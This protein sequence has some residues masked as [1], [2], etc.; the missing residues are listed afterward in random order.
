[1][2]TPSPD[3]TKNIKTE[4]LEE[5]TGDQILD[6]REKGR[7]QGR[8][9]SLEIIMAWLKEFGNVFKMIRFHRTELRNT[10]NTRS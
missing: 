10:N 5:K 6:G 8:N 4:A 9:E 1:M 7:S 2:K 3:M